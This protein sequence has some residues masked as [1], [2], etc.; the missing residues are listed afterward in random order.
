MDE[1]KK[2]KDAA[3]KN[4]SGNF[5]ALRL[6]VSAYLV[7][8]GFDILRDY[9]SGVSTLPIVSAWGFGVGFMVAGLGFALY[10][11]LRYRRETAAENAKGEETGKTPDER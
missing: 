4:R 5:F 2:E 11:F 3:S 6:A 8:L 1:K 10:S 7:Y 9:L